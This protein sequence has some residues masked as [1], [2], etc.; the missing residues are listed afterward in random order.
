MGIA[1][2]ALLKAVWWGTGML[3][4]SLLTHLFLFVCS[5]GYGFLSGGKNRGVK[6]CIPVQLLSGQVFSNF[7]SQ[8]SKV[9]VTRDKNALSA[10]NTHPGAYEWYVVAATSVHQQRTSTD[11]ARWAV[12][13]WAAASLKAVWCDLRLASLLTHLFF[14]GRPM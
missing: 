7:G 4:A 2:A 1:G 5:Y 10:A 11:E 8:R 13:I 14:Y 6:F 3:L 9:K 12:G